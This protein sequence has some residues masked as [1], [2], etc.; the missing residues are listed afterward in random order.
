MKTKVLFPSANA[1]IHP[2]KVGT[3]PALVVFRYNYKISIGRVVYFRYY[4][5]M[6]Y[7]RAI[8]TDRNSQRIFLSLN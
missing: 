5:N 6:V 3:F 8:I 4:D 1:K 7:Y 2:A